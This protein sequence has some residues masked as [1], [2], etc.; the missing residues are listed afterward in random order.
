MKCVECG[1]KLRRVHRKFLQR[2]VYM[3]VY[4]CPACKRE[5]CAPRR[6]RYHFGPACRC[7][8]CGTYRV[9]RLK[10]PD[11]IDRRHSGFLNLLERISG[12]GR[13]FHCR[14]CRLQFFDRRKLAAEIPGPKPVEGIREVNVREAEVREA[15]VRQAEVKD[16]SDPVQ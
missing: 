7:P 2:F 5:E 12:H 9:V 14:W 6:F 1:E 11:R 4:I 15:E 8:L 16:M 10:T 3:A 13:L